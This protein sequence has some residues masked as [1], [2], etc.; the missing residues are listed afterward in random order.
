MAHY[1]AESSGPRPESYSE[2]MEATSA[3]QTEDQ[4]QDLFTDLKSAAETGWDFSSR[5]IFDEAGGNLANISRLQTRRVIPVDLNSFLCGAFKDI[6]FLY[7][8]LKEE[9]AS[10]LWA[11]RGR[12]WQKSVDEVL[13]NE[14]DGIWYDYDGGLNK[15]RR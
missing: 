13:W 9:E 2:D 14:E 12:Q 5:W 8:E 11:T 7:G 10:R 3:L 1:I 4:R 6:A 15:H